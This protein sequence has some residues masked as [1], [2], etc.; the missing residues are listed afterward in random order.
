MRRLFPSSSLKGIQNSMDKKNFKVTV[1]I[2][3]YNEEGN[4]N[5]LYEK[6]VAVLSN[7]PLYEIIFVDDGSTD[8]T[9]SNVKQI[10]LVDESVKYIS[11]SR[12]FGHQNAK[13]WYRSCA[14]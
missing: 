7:Y 4:I 10:I 8:N 3:A 1:I 2:P 9:L 14:W 12:N 6:I 11:F 13:G 5:I